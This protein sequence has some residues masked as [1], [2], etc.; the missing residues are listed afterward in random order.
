MIGI[1]TRSIVATMANAKTGG[2]LAKNKNIGE[3][4]RGNSFALVTSCAV[5]AEVLG[6]GKLEAIADFDGLFKKVFFVLSWLCH[7][8]Q[9]IKKI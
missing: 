2:D 5:T 8:L 4:M 3:A 9:P 7:P 1:N 6:P